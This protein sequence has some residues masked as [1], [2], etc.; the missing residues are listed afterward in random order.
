M[1]NLGFAFWYNYVI[2]IRYTRLPK[3]LI[4]EIYLE[5][6]TF[7]VTEKFTYVLCEQYLFCKFFV[8]I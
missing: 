1:L 5:D 2:M 6:V 4:F 8:K 3:D 7:I